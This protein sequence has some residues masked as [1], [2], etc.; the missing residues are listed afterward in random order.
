MHH[1]T[2]KFLGSEAAFFYIYTIIYYNS[3]SNVTWRHG[4]APSEC[5]LQLKASAQTQTFFC[6]FALT[7]FVCS[8]YREVNN[9]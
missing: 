3:I 1:S 7:I 9:L 6:L 2:Q 8:H 4:V 5:S